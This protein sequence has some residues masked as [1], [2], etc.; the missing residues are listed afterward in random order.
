MKMLLVKDDA[1]TAT[2]AQRMIASN[3]YNCDTPAEIPCRSADVEFERRE[4]P[5]GKAASRHQFPRVRTLNRCQIIYR[6]S[7]CL[8]DCLILNLSDGGTALQ[9]NDYMELPDSFLLE[10]EHGSIH[11][12][13]VCWRDGNKIS[14]RFLN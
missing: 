7:S 1:A 13:E 10:P 2:M 6:N 12:C 11:R 5:R 4:A 9:P 3:G 8:A 14:V